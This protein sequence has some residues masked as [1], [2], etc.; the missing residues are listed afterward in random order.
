MQEA[1]IRF[2]SLLRT[3]ILIALVSLSCSREHWRANQSKPENYFNTLDGVPYVFYHH[4]DGDECDSRDT[5]AEIIRKWQVCHQNTRGW[6]DIAYNVSDRGRRIGVRGTWL[7]TCRC[8]HV[9]LQQ[10]YSTCSFWF[11]FG[12]LSS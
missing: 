4:T 6:D 8:S 9:G 5:C 12:N 7:E 11:L 10:H 3:D 2:R 1:P